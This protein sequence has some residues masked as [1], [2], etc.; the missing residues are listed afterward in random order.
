MESSFPARADSRGIFGHSMGGHGALTIALK[1]PDRYRSVS[2]FAPITAPTRVPHGR[3]ALST[4]LGPDEGSW[5]EH[6]AS[7]LVRENPFPDGHTILISQGTADQFLRGQGTGEQIEDVRLS[8]DVFEEACAESGQPL[9]LRWHEGY[10]HNYYFV[11]TFMED[12]MEH[13]AAALNAT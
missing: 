4:Y 1:N 8:P 7:E 5:R 11:S 6:D 13:H 2:A 12:H 3:E 10:N 9:E